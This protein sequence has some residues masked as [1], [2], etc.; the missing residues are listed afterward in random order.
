MIEDLEQTVIHLKQEIQEAENRRQRQLRVSS[1]H[2][3]HPSILASTS[4]EDASHCSFGWIG[5][6]YSWLHSLL[7]G[8]TNAVTDVC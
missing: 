2:F 3:P 6:S 1:S 4:L 8:V 5:R 7:V